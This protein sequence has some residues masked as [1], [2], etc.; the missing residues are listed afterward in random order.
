MRSIVGIVVA[1]DHFLPPGATQDLY[2]FH[3]VVKVEGESEY[4]RLRTYYGAP[5]RIAT[6]GLSLE[7]DDLDEKLAEI[8]DLFTVDNRLSM[9]VSAP[10]DE[11]RDPRRDYHPIDKVV[12]PRCI[13]RAQ[14]K[15]LQKTQPR[16][17]VI[18]GGKS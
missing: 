10:N 15:V 1:V 12:D 2:E 5:L 9:V 4:I 7:Q 11:A 13:H 3:V 16:F 6:F 18:L 17:E 14:A 8:V